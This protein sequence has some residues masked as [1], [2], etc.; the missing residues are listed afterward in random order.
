MLNISKKFSMP[1]FLTDPE[2]WTEFSHEEFSEEFSGCKF[3]KTIYNLY[4][5]KE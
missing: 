5:M 2:S 3:F 4:E 1:V